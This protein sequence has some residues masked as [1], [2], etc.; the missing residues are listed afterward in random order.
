VHAYLM[1]TM[2][3]FLKKL[4]PA[5]W[6]KD[7]SRVAVLRLQGTIGVGTPLRPGLSLNTIN[8]AIEKAFSL[9]GLSAVALAINSPGGSPVQSAL[10]CERIRQLSGEKQVPVY[11]FVEDVA[12]SGGYWLAMAGDEVYADENSIVGS[13]GVI[14][15]S[16][17]FVDA[18]KK[19][20]IER[21]V[22]TS[23]EN[24]SILDP[25]QPQKKKDVDRLKELQGDIHESFKSLVR[26]RR[27]GK[28]DEKNKDLFSGAFWTGKRALELGLVDKLGT[29]Y[30]VLREIFGEDVD[31]KYVSA[32]KKGLLGRF[33]P[34]SDISAL[35]LGGIKEG[36]SDDVIS[37]LEKRSIWARFGF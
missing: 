5:R 17:G 25:F 3:N 29:M 13:I 33:M 36:W 11:V 7:L 21:R 4:I 12:A 32:A 14:S 6:Q 37:S 34:G 20:G 1:F 24:K 22:Q 2:K 28:L 18:I 15:A 30:P 27:G 26:K 23:G 19:L 35:S 16:F 31:I 10:I 8:P 9:P